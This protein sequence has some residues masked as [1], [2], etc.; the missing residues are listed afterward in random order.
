MPRIN[1]VPLT[2]NYQLVYSELGDDLLLFHEWKLK[3]LTLEQLELTNDPNFVHTEFGK[4]C[5]ARWKRDQ[6]ITSVHVYENNVFKSSGGIEE[7]LTYVQ[8][9]EMWYGIDS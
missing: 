9:K 3:F 7:G 6:K 4:Q 5:N 8:S 2:G 1:G